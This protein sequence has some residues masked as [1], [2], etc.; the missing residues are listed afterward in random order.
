MTIRNKCFIILA[1]CVAHVKLLSA[2]NLVVNWD[3]SLGNTGFESDYN[4]TTINTGDGTRQ[5]NVGA[6]PNAWNPQFLSPPA[7]TTPSTNNFSLLVNGATVAGLDVWR[8]AF[9]GLTP[10]TSLQLSAWASDLYPYDY[11]NPP[12][13]VLQFFVNGVAVGS[14]YTVPY[15]VPNWRMALN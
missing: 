14:P 4:F 6:N 5:Y 1:V 12:P 2:Q 11:T 8:E 10:N 7:W 15:G 9:T 13:V 3:F